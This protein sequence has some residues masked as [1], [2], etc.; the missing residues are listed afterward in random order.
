MLHRSLTDGRG[1]GS[2]Q[3][4]G[5]AVAGALSLTATSLPAQEAALPPDPPAAYLGFRPGEDR[6]LAGWDAITGYLNELASQSDRV[7]IDTLGRSTLDRPMILLTISHPENLRQLDDYRTIQARLADPRRIA[8]PEEEAELLRRGR[9]VVLITSATHASEVGASLLPLR[10]AYRLASSG[11]P[12]VETVLREAVVLIVPAVNP[13]GVDA[14]AEWYRG[15]VDMPWEGA[16]PPFLSHHYLGHDINRD[17]Y[18]LSQQETRLLVER[19][20]NEWHPQIV[21]DIHQQ[22]PDGS[23]FFVPPW[24]DPIEP[25]VDPLLIS[26]A[27]ALGSAIA[28]Q[29]QRQGR[30]GVVVHATYDAWSPSRFYPHYHAGVRLL[31]ETASARMATPVHLGPEDL[32]AERG[33]DP[34]RAS[35]NHP[36]PWRGGRWGL[37]D[38]IDHMEEGAMALLETAARD[39]PQWLSTFVRI[40]RRAVQGWESWPDAWI[41]PA[42]QR[43]PSG[44]RELI[45]MLRAGMVEIGW[46]DDRVEYSGRTLEGGAWVIDMHQPYA[47]YAQALL[48][49]QSYPPR[50]EYEGGPPVEPYDV[51]SH[52]LPLLLGVEVI[53]VDGSVG[54]D[55]VGVGDLPAVPVERI[56]GVSRSTSLLVGLYQS[57]RPEPDEGWT[58]WLFDRHAVPYA[59]LHNADIAQGDLA[60]RFTAIVLPSADPK[61]LRD[62]REEGELPPRY[63]GGLAGAGVQA[64]RDFVLQGGTLVALNRASGFVIEELNLPVEDPLASLDRREFFAPGSLVALEV[65]TSTEAG[66]GSPARTAALLDG[67]AAFEWTVP[68]AGTVVARYGQGPVRLDGWLIG[69]EKLAGRP[70][71]VEVPLGRGRVYLFGF[72]PQFRGHSLA[73]FPLF[74]GTLKRPDAG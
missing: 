39:R 51:T 30:S 36:V 70:A 62:G 37:D 18:T 73:T 23:R 65:D 60:R 14:V 61:A 29:M 26:A 66:A 67:G 24:L 25:N 2:A 42:R 53:P 38:V 7:R 49:S 46:A 16:A 71:L 50:L 19:V 9:L 28:W 31:S 8:D 13:D 58:R 34:A 68:N 47:S 72:R 20:Y 22:R 48:G 5:L 52:N 57:Y 10:L 56:E 21:H 6:A 27:N 74:F 3:S 69:G 35:W 4:L 59:T 64:L 17:W 12:S 32:R 40:G 45:R 33:Y 63:T 1:R 54:A 41:V 11:E 43:G 44:A 55:T 15:T